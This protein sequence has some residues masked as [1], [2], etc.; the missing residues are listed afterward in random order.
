MEAVARLIERVGG[1]LEPSRILESVGRILESVG[2]I[3]A[4]AG[5][6]F[7]AAGRLFAEAGRIFAAA[8]RIFATVD[9]NEFEGLLTR[10][11][12]RAAAASV[13]LALRAAG[14]ETEYEGA[15]RDFGG[16]EA[17]ERKRPRRMIAV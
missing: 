5:R 1:T 16:P 9:P 15:E 11:A 13:R 3:F 7:A 8:G 14:L 6:L 4:A 2:R 10:R 12:A 17:M